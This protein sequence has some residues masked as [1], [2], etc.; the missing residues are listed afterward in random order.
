MMQPQNA[1]KLGLYTWI[2]K[3]ALMGSSCLRKT[4]ITYEPIAGVYVGVLA[5]PAAIPRA[6]VAETGP[7]GNS[8]YLSRV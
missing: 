7:R 8:Y 6:R 5:R 1:C 3:L 2:T 4:L